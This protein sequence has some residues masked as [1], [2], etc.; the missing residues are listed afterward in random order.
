MKI[1]LKKR[2][3]YLKSLIC[4]LKISN[5]ST[6]SGKMSGICTRKGGGGEMVGSGRKVICREV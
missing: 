1:K 2:N 4:W 5:A 6:V 3:F